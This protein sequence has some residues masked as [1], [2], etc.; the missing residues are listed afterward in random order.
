MVLAISEQT[1]INLSYPIIIPI[2]HRKIR[3][4][5]NNAGLIIGQFMQ[6]IGQLESA[7]CPISFLPSFHH[8]TDIDLV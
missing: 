3:L 2:R 8:L 6:H 1:E 7:F 4:T 5:H